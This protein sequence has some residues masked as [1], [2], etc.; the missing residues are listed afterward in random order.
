[1]DRRVHVWQGLHRSWRGALL[2]LTDSWACSTGSFRLARGSCTR[3]T[4]LRRH[5][6][7]A[8]SRPYEQSSAALV[9]P[10]VCHSS[11]ACGQVED[12]G[13]THEHTRKWKS[14][15]ELQAGQAA[16]QRHASCRHSASS[17]QA[18]TCLRA[19]QDRNEQVCAASLLNPCSLQPA[20]TSWLT[21]LRSDVLPHTASGGCCCASKQCIV[22]L[23]PIVKMD[24]N[25]VFGFRILWRWRRSCVRPAVPFHCNLVLRPC[26]LV[27]AI[28]LWQL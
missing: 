22:L 23:N 24:L 15:Q 18:L 8:C 11:S 26:L 2:P 4:E 3:L 9:A 14:L 16:A 5:A 21:L 7:Q 1:M 17:T 25:F 20:R 27:D 10:H 28:L 6:C 12:G 19:L 13:L